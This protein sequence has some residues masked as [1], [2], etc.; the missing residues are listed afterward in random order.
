M[1]RR[2]G[3]GCL[4]LANSYTYSTWGTATTTV[5]AGFGDLGFRYLYVGA[6]DVEWDNSFGLGLL[7]MHARHYSPLIGRFLQPD[8]TGSDT[9]QYAYGSD[10]PTTRS[11]PSGSCWWFAAAALATSETGIGAV[12]NGA[13]FLGCVA[14]V[15]GFSY[16]A[17]RTAYM[18]Q[19]VTRRD[20]WW[21]DEGYRASPPARVAVSTFSRAGFRWWLWRIAYIRANQANQDIKAGRAPR[22]IERVDTPKSSVPGSQSEVHVNGGS[23]N[24]DGTIKH[25]LRSPL[26]NAQK[27]WMT[28]WGFRIPSDGG[29]GWRGR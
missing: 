1:P 5:A 9:N 13:L 2:S 20:S 4:T 27:R 29:S 10:N 21:R 15:A 28:K 19:D 22:G 18:L 11:D 17:A 12:A 23:I 26:T 25:A 7:Y 6:S 14:A 3:G 24:A 8:P 16:Y